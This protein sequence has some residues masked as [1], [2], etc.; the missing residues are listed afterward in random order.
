MPLSTGPSAGGGFVDVVTAFEGKPSPLLDHIFLLGGRIV[1]NPWTG[2]RCTATSRARCSSSSRAGEALG[3][4]DFGDMDASLARV[5][6]PVQYGADAALSMQLVSFACGWFVV[7]WTW[8]TNHGLADGF[9]MCMII[10]SW[11]E[12]ARAG[13]I[14]ATLNF[15]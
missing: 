11:S 6:V 3:S 5:G 9:T 13:T 1:A 2:R 8:S 7:A 10:D 15:D 12:L 14:V 4:L